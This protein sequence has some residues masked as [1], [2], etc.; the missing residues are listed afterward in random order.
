[1]KN[2]S[3]I[4]RGITL[5]FAFAL[6]PCICPS[7]EAHGFTDVSYGSIYFDAVSYCYDNGII[8]GITETQFCPN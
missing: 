2:R 3:G 6:L 7:V 4:L 8:V 5:I 1:M